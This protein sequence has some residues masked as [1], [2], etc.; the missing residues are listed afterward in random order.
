MNEYSLK[1]QGQTNTILEKQTMNKILECPSQE[2][3]CKILQACL[4]LFSTKGYFSTSVDD[5]RREA[6]IS[7]GS[8][9]NYFNNKEAI[10]VALFDDL[11]T[12]MAKA[13]ADIIADYDSAHDRCR[14]AIEYLFE[15][16]ESNPEAMHFIFYAKHSEFLPEAKSICSSEPLTL[17]RQMLTDGIKSGEIKEMDTLVA[18]A[19]IFGIPLRMIRMRLDDVVPDPLPSYLE[20]IWQHAWS[21]VAA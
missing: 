6:Q 21:T 3:R 10:A 11:S 14:A 19:C 15:C 16:T 2:L 13:M 18:S 4:T 1:R 17:M 5:I 20:T 9:Y 12:R 7:V 8:V